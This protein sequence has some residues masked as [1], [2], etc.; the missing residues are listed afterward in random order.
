MNAI[1]GSLSQPQM[2]EDFQ[3]SLSM[4]KQILKRSKD[5]LGRRAGSGNPEKIHERQ[6]QC[7][8]E[9]AQQYPDAFLR[10]YAEEIESKCGVRVTEQA[11]SVHLRKLK[12]TLKNR[13]I[14]PESLSERWQ[15][16]WQHFIAELTQL[17]QEPEV[18]FL[19]GDKTAVYD[20]WATWPGPPWG[21]LW[22][23]S[24]ISEPN[25][26]NKPSLRR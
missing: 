21:Y 13:L 23:T 19:W 15:Q 26:G 6:R 10:E 1:S 5:D 18:E 16:Q 9:Y 22:R 20:D 17:L 4:V 7:I 14:S 12:W 24:T 11:V 25:P 3:V 2:A 8:A